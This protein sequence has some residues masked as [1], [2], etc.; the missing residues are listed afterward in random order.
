VA[1]YKNPAI[2]SLEIS[3]RIFENFSSFFFSFFVIFNTPVGFDYQIFKV[4]LVKTAGGLLTK[5]TKP[6]R[7]SN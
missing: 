7:K 5:D 6:H 1:I 3:S 4:P 2:I